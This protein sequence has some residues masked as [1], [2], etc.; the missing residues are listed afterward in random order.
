MTEEA[1]KKMEEMAP[2]EQTVSSHLG[3]ANQCFKKGFE[4]GYQMQKE[5]IKK[6][7][8]ENAELREVIDELSKSMS[9]ISDLSSHMKL[10]ASLFAFRD[11]KIT[12]PT[13]EA[14]K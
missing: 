4:A 7:K 1:K 9:A 10:A 11:G 3:T 8:A 12:I 2:P 6:L 14:T 5:Q 13:S